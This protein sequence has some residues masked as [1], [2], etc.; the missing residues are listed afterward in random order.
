MKGEKINI[1]KGKKHY[2]KYDS[3]LYKD[4][5][6]NTHTQREEEWNETEKDVNNISFRVAELTGKLCFLLPSFPHFTKGVF[7]F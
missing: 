6:Y 7:S 1:Q 3:N 5:L 2:I 4:V